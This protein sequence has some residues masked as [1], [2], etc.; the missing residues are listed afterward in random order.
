MKPKNKLAITGFILGIFHLPLLLF[1][2]FILMKA[3]F[4]AV[5]QIFLLLGILTV[6]FSGIGLYQ[7]KKT[8]EQGKVLAI[9]GLI[10]GGFFLLLDGV[11]WQGVDRDCINKCNYYPGISGFGLWRIDGKNFQNQKQCVDFCIHTTY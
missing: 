11:A 4:F 1:F 10:I 2:I 7:I 5:F 9:I 6:G 3:S 8:R